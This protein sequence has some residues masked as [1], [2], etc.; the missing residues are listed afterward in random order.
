MLKPNLRFVQAVVLACSLLACTAL[1]G[2]PLP[3]NRA[4]Q[5]EANAVSPAGETLWLQTKSLRLK[6]KVYGSA[7]LGEHPIL[8]VVLHGDLPNPGY[9]YRFAREAA[10]HMDNVVVAA[11]LRPGYTDDSGERSEGV[12]GKTTGDNYTP[13]VVDAVSQ[14]IDQLKE[15]FHPL[16]T[17]L[18]GHS[19]GAAITGDLLGRWPKEVDAALMVSCD[20]DLPAWRKHMQQMQDNNP[21]WSEPVRSLSPLDLAG[22]IPRSVRVRLL[23]GSDDPVAPPELSRKYAD[24]LRR[25]GDDVTLTIAPGLKHNILLEPVAF[26]ALTRLVEELRKSAGG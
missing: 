1:S 18:V 14:A 10:S 4:S 25:H 3:Q 16:R 5:S 15:K 9:H 17:V 23:V 7:R 8:I 2:A 6:S 13:E 12:Q 21:V 26:D 24:E 22:D 20:C 19:G 11:L